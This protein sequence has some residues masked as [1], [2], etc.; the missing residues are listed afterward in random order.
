MHIPVIMF[1]F[2]IC[3]VCAASANLEVDVVLL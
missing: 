1:D 2:T 3:S